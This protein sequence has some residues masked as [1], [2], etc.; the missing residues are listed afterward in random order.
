MSNGISLCRLQRVGFGS[1]NGAIGW[2]LLWFREKT[3]RSEA[4]FTVG[5]E[6]SGEV[7]R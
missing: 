1:P 4:R 3:V 5:F 7:M 6:P 2:T